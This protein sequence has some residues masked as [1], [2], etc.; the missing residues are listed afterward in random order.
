MDYNRAFAK[1]EKKLSS[2]VGH[3]VDL[4]FADARRIN[5]ST[6]HFM[7]AYT[8]NVP[9]SDE[10]ADFFIRKYNAKITPFLST[11]RVYKTQKV[12][13]VVGQILSITRDIEDTK[14][15]FMKPV[16]EGAVYLDVPLQETWEVNERE[17]RKVL[18]RKVKDDIMALVNARKKTM[19]DS[20]ST[21][22]FASLVS[23]ENV[24]R[25]LAILDKGDFIRVLMDEKIVEAEVV[26]IKDEQVKIKYK[27][28]LTA[29]PRQNV[30]EIVGKNPALV[31]K[32]EQKVVDYFTEAYGDEK[33]AEKLV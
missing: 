12:V 28:K 4:Q 5:A 18:V 2:S 11:A 22:T 7:L 1:L 9:T 16:I 3:R 13:T 30:L 14:K 15:S 32:E 31:E 20:Y 17:G 6:A 29:V 19:M 21:K 8:D 10:L 26:S 25:Y 23:A 27:G 33:Y 24:T